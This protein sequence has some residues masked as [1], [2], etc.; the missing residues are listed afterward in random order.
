MGAAV[1]RW[2]RDD[3]AGATPPPGTSRSSTEPLRTLL[4][5][6]RYL[7]ESRAAAGTNPATAKAV[8]ALEALARTKL[9]AG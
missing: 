5:E 3:R 7:Q 6:G 1:P 4:W 9:V 2:K 8:A